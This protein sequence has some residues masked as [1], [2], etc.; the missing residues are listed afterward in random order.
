M[1]SIKI[2]IDFGYFCSPRPEVPELK[3]EEKKKK[4]DEA[5]TGET[6]KSGGRSTAHLD[7]LAT[8]HID[9]EDA[10]NII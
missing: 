4:N 3:I 7:H 10:K 2:F 5:Q 1:G 8:N 9:N 6:T